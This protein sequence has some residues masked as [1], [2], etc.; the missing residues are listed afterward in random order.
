MAPSI[1]PR[2]LLL[3]RLFRA[4]LLSGIFFSFAQ[5]QAQV[6]AVAGDRE[7]GIEFFKHGQFSEAVTA[8]QK[9]AKLNSQDFDTWYYLGLAQVKTRDLKE[10]THS[11]ETAARIK[12]GSA[13]AHNGLAY[14]L[15]FRNKLP[16]AVREAQ[17]A[18]SIDPTLAE[19]HY[20]IG[21]ARLRADARQEALVEAEAAIKLDPKHAAA[22]LLKSQALVSLLGDTM[23]FDEKLPSQNRLGRYREAAAALEK[24]LQ[25]NPEG[26]DKQTWIDQLEGLRAYSVFHPPNGPDGA[27]L[28]KDVMVKAKVLSKPAAGY[29]EV[30]RRNEISGT[31]VLKAI[32]GSDG[33]V[34]QIVVIK[35]LPYGL[36]ERCIGA[37][38]AI[39]FI[40]ATIGGKPVSQFITLEYSFS[41]Y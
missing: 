25:L 41:L 6:A 24:Y 27:Y 28:T 13:P 2:A 7:R 19:A 15:L 4:L 10:A 23:M 35:A 1:G 34:K 17:T 33:K 14:T 30:A 8:L 39:K 20:F 26:P 3:S 40:P 29:T 38:L 9:A 21:V 22:Y 31:V 5:T 16:A 37:A 12:P 11:F 32:F 36:T 18:L